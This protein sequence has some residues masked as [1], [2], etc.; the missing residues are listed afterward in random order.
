M[1]GANSILVSVK[2]ASHRFKTEA[3]IADFWGNNLQE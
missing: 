3:A 1:I 2:L